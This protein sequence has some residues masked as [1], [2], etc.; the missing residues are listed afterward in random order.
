MERLIA[1]YRSRGVLLDSNLLI[2]LVVGSYDEHLI[3][4]FKRTR[5]FTVDDY[6]L[7]CA[8]LARFEA[9]ATT[10]SVLTEVSNLAQPLNRRENHRLFKSFGALIARFRERYAASDVLSKTD[11]FAR[12]GLTDAS[13]GE[14]ARGSFLA[15]TDDLPLYSQLIAH[16]I[17]ALNFNHLRS[18]IWL[19]P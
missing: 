16:G 5:T 1:R 8:F 4:S 13:I 18:A 7:L 14:I 19:R 2:V 3:R 10:P 12:H 15:L 9:I 11:L 6:H 17:D